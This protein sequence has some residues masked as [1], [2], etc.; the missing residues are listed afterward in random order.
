MSMRMLAESGHRFARFDLLSQLY[1]APGNVLPVGVLA[2]RLVTSSGNISRL[3]DR[4][5]TDG[6]VKRV[7][8]VEDRRRIDIVLT[9]K[10]ERAFLDMAKVHAVWISEA[11]RDL[12][13]RTLEEIEESLRRIDLGKGTGAVSENCSD[14][15]PDS[16]AGEALT[17]ADA[18]G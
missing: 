16:H 17:G 11:L 15:R 14:P 5:E 8:S 4:I 12:D 6:L 13:D 7:P 1:R 10:G 9:P 2:G 3:L 18:V